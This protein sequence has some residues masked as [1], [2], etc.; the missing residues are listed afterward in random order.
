MATQHRLPTPGSD[1]G[2]WGDILNDFLVQIHN[3]DGSLASGVVGASQIQA[4]VV[5][6]AHL[7]SSAAITK[8]KLAPDVQTS[9]TAADNATPK[10][11]SGTDGKPLKWNNT[12]G[13]LEDATTTLNATY[14]PLATTPQRAGGT[15]SSTASL[16]F[17][18]AKDYGARGDTV[19]VTDAA[20]TGGTNQLSSA[21]AA[22]ITADA[23]KWVTITGAGAAGVPVTIPITSVSAGIASLQS[24]VTTTVSGA[25]ATYGTDDTA[26]INATITAANVASGGGTAFVPKGTYL[27]TGQI[28][29][30][31]NVELRGDGSLTVF[32]PQY[33][34]ANKATV[35]LNDLTNGGSNIT[36]RSFRLDR[37]GNNVQN[38][39]LLN[40]I[41]NLLVSELEIVGAPSST[42]GALAVS[43][44]MPGGSG[45]SQL[46]SKNVRVRGC[47]F[48]QVNNFG[49]Q[50]S[51]VLNATVTGC[52]FDDCY[53]EAIGVEPEPGCVAQNVA[54]T[55]N[56]LT[57]STV[58][59]GGSAT[60]VVVI[61][62]SSGGTINGCTVS[63]NTVAN[64][65]ITS[66][67]GNPGILVLGGKGVV[68]SGNTVQG[69]NGNGISIGNASVATS[70]VL[71]IGNQVLDCNAQNT[72]SFGGGGISL[73][74]ASKCILIGNHVNGVHHTAS[75]YESQSGT[76]QNVLAFNNFDDTVPYVLLSGS[77][78]ITRDNLGHPTGSGGRFA[79][80]VSYTM[81]VTDQL[82]AVTDTT[83]V[84]TITLPAATAVGPGAKYTIKDESGAAATNNITIARAGADTIEGATSLV[85]STNYGKATLYS[86]GTSKWLA[87]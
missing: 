77:R 43:G 52:V 27:L 81:L 25:A 8:T 58:P 39:I 84:R 59:S 6:D 61:T 40:G 24:N 12:S 41:S 73:R 74:Q 33:P 20:I 79:T 72:S 51:W 11:V 21:S 14:A 56:T 75:V 60:G 48:G 35:M 55:G 50:L 32:L 13:Q 54:I 49:V 28:N 26:A 66:A 10:P 19:T 29:L 70:N 64:M 62:E 87:I 30:K 53:R 1:N 7:S 80:A 18:N 3:A 69:M 4:G 38:G 16:P 5:T 23:G 78:A 34:S 85:I 37:S 65:T 44:I 46:L 71:I 31:S 76:T 22:F 63:G 15:S 9:L 82:V 83:S 17:F 57:M 68:L 47:Y 86:D 36:L 42:S 67:N 2:T 45:I